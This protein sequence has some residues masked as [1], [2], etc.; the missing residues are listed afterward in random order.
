M[1][2]LMKKNLNYIVMHFFQQIGK[3]N[4]SKNKDIK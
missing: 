2:D 3:D 4:F 1:F